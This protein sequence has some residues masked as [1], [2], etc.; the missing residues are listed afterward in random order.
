M[1]ETTDAQRW[2]TLFFIALIILVLVGGILAARAIIGQDDPGPAAKEITLS[3]LVVPAGDF[4]IDVS[5]K[6]PTTG[7]AELVLVRGS[8]G[9]F[10]ITTAAIDGF[11]A[12]IQFTL[13]G[14]P[15]G[16]FSFSANPVTPG[17]STTLTINSANLQSNV[18]YVTT[19][20]ADD[21]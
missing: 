19:L 2:K 16:S 5:P 15:P 17:A 3:I 6:N 1:S 18:I 4:T 14:L 11:D 7:D 13:D 10:T 20:T 21:I 9:Q 8:S 12:Q